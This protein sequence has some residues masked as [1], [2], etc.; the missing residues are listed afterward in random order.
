MSLE[1]PIICWLTINNLTKIVI[2]CII[3]CACGC[4]ELFILFKGLLSRTV[5]A[6]HLN[7]LPSQNTYF[8]QLICYCLCYITAHN[9]IPAGASSYLMNFAE[10]LQKFSRDLM[11]L[12]VLTLSTRVREGQTPYYACILIFLCNASFSG[13]TSDDNG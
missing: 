2:R 6:S 12:G 5:I 10:C 8:D 13:I 1:R 7:M 11:S 9:I 3:Y 4:F